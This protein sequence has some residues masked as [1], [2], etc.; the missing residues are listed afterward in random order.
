VG[1]PR[2]TLVELPVRQSLRAADHRFPVRNGVGN[3]L[4]Q[5]GDV[6]RRY[7]ASLPWLT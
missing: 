2:G 3:K 4:E 5:V 7:F 1:K 6:E